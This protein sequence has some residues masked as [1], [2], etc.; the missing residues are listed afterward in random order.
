MVVAV[1]MLALPAHRAW[2]AN[3]ETLLMPGKLSKAHAKYEESCANCHDKSDKSR[4]T[5]LCLDCHKDTRADIANKRGFHGHM[6]NAEG[7]ACRAC[8]TEHKGREADIVRFTPG[9]FDHD[10]TSFALKGSHVGITCASC[11]KKSEPYRKAVA[12]CIACHR[13]K[14]IHKNTLGSKCADCHEPTAWAEV[15]FDHDKTSFAL[16]DAHTKIA[17]DTCH[18]GPRYKNTPK[19]CVDCH[20]PDDI[21]R[22]DRGEDC[23]K[24]HTM[25]DWKSAKYDHLKETGF[26][27]KDAHAD[28]PCTA[29]HTTGNYKDKIPKECVG[30]HKAQDSHASRL[31]TDCGSCHTEVHWKPVEYDHLKSA[32][33]A[34]VGV[35]A[36]LG[37]HDCHTAEVKKQKL[38][39]TCVDCHRAQ[40]P[41]GGE[42]GKN[43]DQCHG[44]ET[45]RGK[46]SFDHDLTQY[47]LL[48]QHVLVSCA[49]CHASLSFKGASQ[50]CVDCHRTQDV[51]KGGLG[52]ECQSCHSPNGWKIWEFDHAKETR[53]ALTGAHRK[54][55][56]NDCHREPPKK[57]KLSSE[58]GAC[59]A[60]D[61][62]HIGEFGRQCQRCHTTTSFA[63]AKIR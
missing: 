42:L 24:C 36:K 57:V 39:Q 22:G 49:Q 18:F 51:H 48:G 21:H 43:C 56:C 44:N 8:H 14:D 16:H 6:A 62:I 37:C 34:L 10:G 35:H 55:T 54:L 47:P 45:W 2:S 59:H 33:F 12:D 41:H 20:A 27:L 4:Q 61:D 58:C 17:C 40:D 63:A 31:G 13:D 19:R 15:H 28:I 26:A 38:G 29:C 52:A 9:G 3:V 53:F 1:A 50:K 11:H 5:A 30:C 23:G 46:V 7:S 60:K 32:K 25:V